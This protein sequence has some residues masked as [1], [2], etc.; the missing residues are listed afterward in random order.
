[1][2]V[3]RGGVGPCTTVLAFVDV[4]REL[5]LV[6]YLLRLNI[7]RHPPSTG[8]RPGHWP[9]IAIRR[10]TALGSFSHQHGSFLKEPWLV[11]GVVFP[12]FS[13]LKMILYYFI[14]YHMN[15][16]KNE[17]LKLEETSLD[18]QGHFY[19]NFLNVTDVLWGLTSKLHETWHNTYICFNVSFKDLKTSWIPHKHKKP[20]MK[21]IGDFVM[22]HLGR[23]LTFDFQCT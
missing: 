7:K 12:D 19:A 22:E 6:A 16:L 14:T 18:T 2:I 8:R 15:F 17:Q 5:E 21:H 10:W 3:L 9:L 1:M 4:F 23:P 20:R 13:N 11:L